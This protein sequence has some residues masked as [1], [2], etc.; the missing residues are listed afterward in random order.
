M[1]EKSHLPLT[2]NLTD[3]F[4][5]REVI[6]CADLER[7]QILLKSATSEF[8][9]LLTSDVKAGKESWHFDASICLQLFHGACLSKR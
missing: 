3:G 9:I 8:I 4:L 7:I 2:M 1:K 6:G 5:S